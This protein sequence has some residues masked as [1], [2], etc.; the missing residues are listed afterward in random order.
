M[1]HCVLWRVQPV[2]RERVWCGLYLHDH[3]KGLTYDSTI[4][5]KLLVVLYCVRGAV[6]TFWTALRSDLYRS[7]IYYSWRAAFVSTIIM[8]RSESR[9]LHLA[10]QG[11]IIK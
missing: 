2:A 1:L 6:L 3:K 10:A 9:E 11:K 7:K 5:I 8:S 4:D